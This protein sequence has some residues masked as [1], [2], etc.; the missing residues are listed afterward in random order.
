MKKRVLLATIVF[1]SVVCCSKDETKLSISNGRLSGT[2]I[3][4]NRIDKYCEQRMKNFKLGNND[5]ESTGGFNIG[6]FKIQ[7]S[8][9]RMKI[10]NLYLDNKCT[11]CDKKKW[12]YEYDSSYDYEVL[13]NT[14]ILIRDGSRENMEIEVVSLKENTLIIKFPKGKYHYKRGR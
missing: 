10:F 14:L 7:F 8:K 1:L 11:I 6:A 5:C 2:W 3:L 13:G 9:K 4:E 12:V